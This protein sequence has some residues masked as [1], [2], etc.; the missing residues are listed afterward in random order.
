MKKLFF[1]FISAMICLAAAPANNKGYVSITLNGSKIN[2]TATHFPWPINLARLPAS[3]WKNITQS[4]DIVITDTLGNVKP[5]YVDPTFN[6]TTDSGIITFDASLDSAKSK[7]YFIYA[8][9]G[10]SSS[11]LATVFTNSNCVVRYSM[12]NASSPLTD[13]C[14][15]YNLTNYNGILAQS[16]K[17]GKALNV[18]S[19][20][21]PYFSPILQMNG[22]TAWTRSFLIN[23]SDITVGG[24]FSG[25]WF[26]DG[27]SAW[28]F[29]LRLV[30]GNSLWCYYDLNTL[31]Y[32]KTTN[33]LNTYITSNT[34]HKFDFVF[35]GASS[36]I[37]ID[38]IS[39]PTTIVGTLPSSLVTPGYGYIGTP[40][41]GAAIKFDELRDYSDVKSTGWVLTE[42]NTIFDTSATLYGSFI[43]KNSSSKKPFGFKF[44]FGF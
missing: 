5:C 33:A 44:G 12:D 17:I 25:G 42:Y 38:G 10:A 23:F 37:I 26:E 21:Y 13:A 40:L 20:A 9:P 15:N 27:A 3:W 8:V 31:S 29:V 7:R 6:A 28:Q 43:D 41:Y 24:Y 1:I 30:S 16:G 11:N 18:P 22:A 39:V 19:N 32:I 2:T 36:K 34:W 14:G 35:A 4:G